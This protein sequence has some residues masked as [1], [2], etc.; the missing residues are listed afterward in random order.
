[1]SCEKEE[2]EEI[3]YG[4]YKIDSSAMYNSF[5][6]TII[7]DKREDYF[8]CFEDKNIKPQPNTWYRTDC[9]IC[10]WVKTGSDVSSK[11]IPFCYEYLP[12]PYTRP[13]Q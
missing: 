2:K 9:G 10:E 13:F 6:N 3:N 8:I 7:Y 1:M 5:T 12:T 11:N 4:V